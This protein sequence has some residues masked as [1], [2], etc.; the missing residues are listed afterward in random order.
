MQ[1]K[2]YILKNFHFEGVLRFV[3]ECAWTHTSTVTRIYL[4]RSLGL[5]FSSRRNRFYRIISCA[6]HRVNQL[7]RGRNNHK[8]SW[9]DT[10]Y[11]GKS[12]SSRPRSFLSRRDLAEGSVRARLSRRRLFYL[13]EVSFISPRSLWHF[14]KGSTRSRLPWVQEVFLACGEN[15]RCWPKA[16]TSSAIGE[17]TKTRQKP[18]TALEKSPVPRVDL[19]EISFISERS[20]PKHAK[21]SAR[22]HLSGWNIFI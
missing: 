22:S 4:S 15:F 11:L 9:R 13:G 12:P 7:T 14:L 17:A 21:I 1:L 18:E 20:A 16:D 6:Y 10:S 5:F 8:N 19:T 2:T 3:I